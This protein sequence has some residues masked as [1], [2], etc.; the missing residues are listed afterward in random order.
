MKPDPDDLKYISKGE[1]DR[2]RKQIDDDITALD[3]PLSL[4]AELWGIIGKGF[5]IL[6]D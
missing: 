3:M 2:A 6:E 4:R 5:S 1:I